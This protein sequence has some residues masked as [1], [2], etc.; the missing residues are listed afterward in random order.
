M[1]RV[2]IN[3]V[4]RSFLARLPGLLNWRWQDSRQP[5]K[6]LIQQCSARERQCSVSN[7]STCCAYFWILNTSTSHSRHEIPLSALCN[8]HKG[9]EVLIVSLSVIMRLVLLKSRS[10]FLFVFGLLVRWL[11]SRRKRKRLD[12]MD[13]EAPH[14]RG[15]EGGGVGWSRRAAHMWWNP[16]RPPP[17][18]S[19]SLSQAFLVFAL[20]LRFFTAR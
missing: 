7:R 13:M 1:E 8:T 17:P 6:K 4:R 15:A 18:S 19:S 5:R 10:L 11:A 14:A 9:C 2:F 20:S 3:L 16:I 12:R